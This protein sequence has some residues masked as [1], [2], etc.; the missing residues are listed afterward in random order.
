MKQN[1]QQI[2][3]NKNKKKAVNLA[4]SHGDEHESSGDEDDKKLNDDEP[5]EE[6]AKNRSEERKFKKN[7]RVPAGA[8]KYLK[9]EIQ[10]PTGIQN[11]VLKSRLEQSAKKTK[12]AA[13][14]AMKSEILLQA[15]AGFIEADEGENTYDLTQNEIVKHVDIQTSAKVFD[16]ELAY[17]PYSMDFTSNGR[18]LLL[19]GDRG[20]I[21]MMDWSRGKKQM[22][23]HLQE[24]ARD[25]CFLHNETMF[26]VAQRKY[27]YIYNNVGHQLHQ[28]TSHFDPKF[29][30]FLPYHFLLVSATNRGRL[31]YEDVSIG[32]VA[33]NH[34][35]KNTLS[36]IAVNPSNAVVNLGYTNG[37]VEMWIPKAHEPVV[38]VLCHKTAIQA[39]AVSHSGAYLLTAG[40]D[41]MVKI[42]DLRNTYEEMHS[43]KV[44][45]QPHAMSISDMNV[46]AVA[47]GSDT[48]LWKNPFD[49]TITEPY[50][51]HRTSSR[52]T[53]VRFCPFEDVLGI[54]TEKG[55]S[56]ILVPG[57]GQPNYDS[58]EA[59]PYSTLK[60]RR[61]KE[62][63]SLLDKI[64]SDMITLNPNL[65]GTVQKGA[66][67]E[68]NKYIRETKPMVQKDRINIDPKKLERMTAAKK[69]RKEKR[70][71]EILEPSKTRDALSRF[72][73]KKFQ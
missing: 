19:A 46:L 43:F 15:E 63:H 59:D 57:A 55:Y 44:K 60:M 8:R 24:P 34:K 28:L 16:F 32:N 45:H 38:R 66:R 42:F 68:E 40:L 62:V 9:G 58:L 17:G 13:M 11:P 6:D 3:S 51:H 69:Q 56:S 25:A 53:A 2:Q 47:N 39:M 65:I 29:V 41:R 33:A 7:M 27:T 52:A 1:K 64:P 49:P 30:R 21:A 14:S 26:A 61:E 72:G 18:H 48:V 22:E 37:V 35:F 20:H 23:T 31:I 67:T 12:Y 5:N 36:A 54:G 73:K 10:A 70:E 71:S 50:I 4:K